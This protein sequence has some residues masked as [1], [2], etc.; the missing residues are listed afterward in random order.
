MK[1]K[2]LIC[3]IQIDF[4]FYKKKNQFIDILWDQVT[5]KFFWQKKELDFIRMHGYIN[6]SKKHFYTYFYMQTNDTWM[7]NIANF[8]DFFGRIL[9][10]RYGNHN[11]LSK[12][13]NLKVLKSLVSCW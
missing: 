9:L 10:Y 5:E 13:Q 6:L 11:W 2:C 1:L 3:Y 12:I 4:F 7:I 8:H